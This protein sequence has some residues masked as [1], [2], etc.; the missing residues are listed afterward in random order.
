[1]APKL[2][3][4]YQKQWPNWAANLFEGIIDVTGMLYSWLIFAVGFG[5]AVL[6]MKIIPHL[7]L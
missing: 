7:G 5:A 1:M 2:H 4:K 3:L 6:F